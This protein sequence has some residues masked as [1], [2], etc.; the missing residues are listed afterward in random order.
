ME[1]M[2]K[3][4]QM[5]GMPFFDVSRLLRNCFQAGRMQC[6]TLLTFAS[7]SRIGLIPIGVSGGC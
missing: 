1:W 3:G 2:K 4:F 7:L 6:E 5:T